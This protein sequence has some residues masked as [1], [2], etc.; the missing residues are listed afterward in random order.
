VKLLPFN[1]TS[2]LEVKENSLISAPKAKIFNCYY[3]SAKPLNI[4]SHGMVQNES[5]SY[6]NF[7]PK[8]E[9]ELR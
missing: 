9:Q 3:F 5:Q 8:P 2:F 1:Y 7:P 6:M 4:Y